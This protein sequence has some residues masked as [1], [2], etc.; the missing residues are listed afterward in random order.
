[1]KHSRYSLFVHNVVQDAFLFIFILFVLTVYRIAFLALFRDALTPQTTWHSIFL[2]LWYGLRIGLKTTGACVLPAFVLGTLLQAIWPKWNG[3]KLR[4]WWASVVLLIL[5]LLFQLRIPYYQEFHQAFSPFMFN[6]FH[7]DV[8]A[9]VS[10][11]IDQYHAV[12]RTLAGFICTFIWCWLCRKWLISRFARRIAQLFTSVKRPWL[13]VGCFCIFLVPFAIFV[14]E[15]GAFTFNKSIYWKNAARMDQHLLNEAILDDVQAFYRARWMYKRLRT[16]AAAVDGQA[17]RQA[18]ARL[19]GQE[20]Y[21]AN[22]LLPLLSRKAGGFKGEK[23]KHI[24]VIVAETYMLWPLL[25]EYAQ[26]PLANGM[27]RLLQ[28]PDAVLFKHFLPIS[29]GTMFGLTAVTL[30]IPELDLQA[31]ARQTAQQPYETALPVQL[32]KQG[33]KTRFFYGGF[34]S[35]DD[36]GSFMNNQQ[37]EESVYG[38]SFSGKASVWGVPDRDFLQGIPNFIGPESSFNLIL[39]SSNHPPY[40]V[41]ISRET[42]LPSVQD[43]EKMIEGMPDQSLMASRMWHFAY[44]DKYLAEFVEQ[45]LAKEPNSLFLIVGDHADRWTLTA[46]P[47][48]YERI[49]VPLIIIGPQ[50]K[51]K[52]V[53][54]E[55]A[56]THMDIASTV[57]EM[58]LD[59]DA[60]Y[61]ALGHNMLQ[62]Q[63]EGKLSVGVGNYYWITPT[64]IAHITATDSQLLPGVSKGLSEEEKSKVRQYANDIHTIAGWRIL[65]GI[66]LQEETAQ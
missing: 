29:H 34:P 46:S 2:T 5:S 18:A 12:W 30:G 61:Y 7:D 14:R 9:I 11:S 21:T 19:M 23:P 59:K 3:T 15:G 65:K 44:A 47:S 55:T 1:M 16:A 36:V 27:R 41:D 49:A 51:N 64:D 58:I 33:Y 4:F 25:D 32:R 26:Y 63:K 10:T 24:F 35:W 57:L 6:T 50:L 17:A 20:S 62:T 28:R 66:S 45:M 37:F 40:R 13:A 54:L 60:P 48:D 52:K 31:N 8:G 56:G 39:T 43:F 38:P 22:D 53:D 42:E